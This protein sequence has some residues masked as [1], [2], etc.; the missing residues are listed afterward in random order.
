MPR[1]FLHLHNDIDAL[2]EE[3]VELADIAAAR[4]L[5]R[6]SVQFA[7]AESIKDNARLVLDHRIDIA[8]ESGAII[9]TVRFGDVVKVET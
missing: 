4:A 8:D 1:Y 2:D 5:A 7:A 9:E 6:H 3:G